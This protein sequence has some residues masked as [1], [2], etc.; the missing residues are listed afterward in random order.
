MAGAEAQRPAPGQPPARILADMDPTPATCKP[1]RSTHLRAALM[2]GMGLL[3]LGAVGWALVTADGDDALVESA[4][5]P[6]AMVEDTPSGPSTATL[7]ETAPQPITPAD[8]PFERSVVP[9]AAE[10]A[11]AATDPVAAT[12]A[13]AAN[14]TAAPAASA[15]PFSAM[16]APARGPANVRPASASAPV[17]PRPT[18]TAKPPVAS[19][20]RAATPPQPAKE[21]G[22]LQTLMDNIQQPAE[23]VRDTR[24]MD[25][26]AKRLDRTPMT[27]STPVG[28]TRAEAPATGK[29]APLSPAEVRAELDRCPIGS[30][31]RAEWCRRRVC[32]RAGLDPWAC[33]QR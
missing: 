14:A 25:R 4:D 5:A 9:D 18:A 1:R 8:N 22:L 31:L 29:P 33:G 16:Q 27:T 15:N 19:A 28:S 7:V 24:G 12:L 32:K 17:A 3:A 11:E 26:L 20:P 13:A 6:M 21:A 23:P 30:N 2:A 10:P